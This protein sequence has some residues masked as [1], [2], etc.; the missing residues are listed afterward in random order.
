MANLDKVEALNPQVNIQKNG[1]NPASLGAV[2]DFNQQMSNNSTRKLGRLNNNIS[3]AKRPHL[4]AKSFYEKLNQIEHAKI[5]SDI[6]SDVMSEM[7]KVKDQMKVMKGLDEDYLKLMGRFKELQALH[8]K[9]SPAS[10]LS[11]GI[12]IARSAAGKIPN[13]LG[14]AASASNRLA[15]FSV[16]KVEGFI[17]DD[18]LVSHYH[19]GFNAFDH[20][21]NGHVFLRIDGLN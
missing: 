14:V 18:P 7:G 9:Y 15:N 20:N 16:Y 8:I 5:L 2:N 10:V 21:G 6:R 13:I 1:K 19:A 12:A 11:Q 17:Y 3:E 4:E